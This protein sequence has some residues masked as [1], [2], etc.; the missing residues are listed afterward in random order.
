QPYRMVITDLTLPG[1][2]GLAEIIELVN[3]AGETPLTVVSSGHSRDV[4]R[5]MRVCGVSGLLERD[6][7]PEQISRTLAMVLRGGL[8][9]PEIMAV[10]SAAALPPAQSELTSRQMR[11]LSLLTKGKSNK[12][13]AKDLSLSPNTVKAH[14]SEILRKLEVDGRNEVIAMAMRPMM[15]L[16]AAD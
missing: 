4:H 14:V 15:T 1:V 2:R 8:A 12:Q 6:A 3:A 5:R 16:Q 10:P 9:F 11:V 13:I 7:P